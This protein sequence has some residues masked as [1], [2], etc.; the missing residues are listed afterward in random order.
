MGNEIEIL[1][2]RDG[3]EG[4]AYKKNLV[5]EIKKGRKTRKEQPCQHTY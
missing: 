5:E 1:S 2:W 3:K 4:E